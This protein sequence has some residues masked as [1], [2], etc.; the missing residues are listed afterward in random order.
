MK[1]N[2]FAV[3]AAAIRFRRR[4]SNNRV[5]SI[6]SGFDSLP[7]VDPR[8]IWELRRSFVKTCTESGFSLSGCVLRLVF[9]RGARSGHRPE[10][11]DVLASA[12][13]HTTRALVHFGRRRH[14]ASCVAH[15]VPAFTEKL[16]LKN[17]DCRFR[18]RPGRA[19]RSDDP[20][21]AGAGLEL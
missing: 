13:A 12:S 11:E 4:L 3:F 6:F 14:V 2:L 15:A 19:D 10:G 17:L 9:V 8:Q 1:Q 18:R 5:K 20:V 7:H 16:A 21:D